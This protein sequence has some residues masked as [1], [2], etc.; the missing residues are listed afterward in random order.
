M[1]Q[2]QHKQKHY[3]SLALYYK[4]LAKFK[5]VKACVHLENKNDEPFWN[6]M[7]EYGLP[8]ESFHFIS[9][10]KS[11]SGNDTTGC[12]QCLAYKDYLSKEFVVCIDS[13]YRYLL[14]EPDIDI[15]H[16]IFQT[17]T[18]SFENHLCISHGLSDVVRIAC[19]AENDCYDFEL[20]FKQYSS[21]IY[22]LFVWH[23]GLLR[24][25]NEG[26]SKEEFQAVV[27]RQHIEVD[28]QS[29]KSLAIIKD[30]VL[31]KIKD[32][33]IKFPAFDLMHEKEKLKAS[34]V[35]EENVYL[36]IR[37]HNLLSLTTTLGERVR[38]KILLKRKA[39]MTDSMEIKALYDTNPHF[40]KTITYNKRF[41]TYPEICKIEADMRKYATFL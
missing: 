33:E 19:G 22:D 32:L 40:D 41:G 18:Y 5:R 7:F 17:Y 25:G 12:E 16:F 13:D 6:S 31:A 9:Y 8:N 26:F 24:D 23:I 36:Y 3:Q 21:V 20:F 38:E 29:N 11:L 10:S 14:Q 15:D 34:G 1:N 27:I 35:F 30:A 39:N 4:N 2:T 37:G 28:G